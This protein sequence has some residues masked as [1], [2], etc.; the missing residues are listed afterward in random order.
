MT[1]TRRRSESGRVP[2]TRAGLR[3]II[4]AAQGAERST[5]RHL[6]FRAAPRPPLRRYYS[7]AEKLE[8][9][10]AAEAGEDDN[11]VNDKRDGAGGG[12]GDA[13]G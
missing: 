7:E 4:P 9:S 5:K 13:T 8:E 11:Q 12:G 6:S 3:E 10:N 1:P 2:P